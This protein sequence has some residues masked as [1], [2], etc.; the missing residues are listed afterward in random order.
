M[1]SVLNQQNKHELDTQRLSRLLKRLADAYGHP[2]SVITLALVDNPAIEKLNKEYLN[3]NSP[4]DVLSFP[5]R[6]KSPDG[7]FYLGDIIISVP[8][9]FQQSRR[10]NHGLDR[11]LEILCIHGFLHLNGYEHGEGLEKEEEKA[12]KTMLKGYH[13]C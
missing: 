7:E 2:E 5:I 9:A 13:G 4:T 6:E 12:R 8:Y 10:L 3:K 11:E 1:I